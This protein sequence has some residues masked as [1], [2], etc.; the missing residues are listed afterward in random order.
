VI[1]ILLH[2]RKNLLASSSEEFAC[3]RN[4]S[5]V[6]LANDVWWKNEHVRMSPAPIS[7]QSSKEKDCMFLIRLM[8][9]RIDAGL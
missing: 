1:I 9:L 8:L 6:G 4:A 2:D 5:G 7:M 3:S